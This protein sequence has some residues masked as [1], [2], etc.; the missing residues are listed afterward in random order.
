[1][2]EKEILIAARA[3]IEDESHWTQFELARDAS[4]ELVMP[5]SPEAVRW[6]ALGALDRVAWGTSGRPRARAWEVFRAV[7]GT[8]SIARI[9]DSSTHAEILAAFDKAIEAAS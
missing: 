9:N 6:C 3:L 2:T 4:G 1:M 8:R 7:N 5:E